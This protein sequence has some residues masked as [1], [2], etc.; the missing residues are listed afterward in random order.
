MKALWNWCRDI[1]G[2]E[3]GSDLKQQ[4]VSNEED[5]PNWRNPNEILSDCNRITTLGDYDRFW[6]NERWKTLNKRALDGRRELT[7]PCGVRWD[8][9]SADGHDVDCP[10]VTVATRILRWGMVACSIPNGIETPRL[11]EMSRLHLGDM[12][13][14]RIE[15]DLTSIPEEV[16]ESIATQDA[17][18]CMKY[19]LPG[20]PTSHENVYQVA[21]RL[22][23]LWCKS[24]TLASVALHHEFVHELICTFPKRFAH[25]DGDIDPHYGYQSFIPL[26][27]RG[28]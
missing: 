6:A 4:L 2:T 27:V 7:V 14:A 12:R 21:T 5:P 26:Q 23:S 10:S 16:R 11:T 24:Y 1:E 15:L 19:L 9:P 25:K 22:T 13:R 17:E 20:G 3:R 8:P 18:R 28:G